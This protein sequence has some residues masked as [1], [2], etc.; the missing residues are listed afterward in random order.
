M[1]SEYRPESLT[2]LLCC[3]IDW[4]H[5]AVDICGTLPSGE[6]LL[7]AI[8]Y[9]STW[10]EI[11]MLYSTST[12]EVVNCLDNWFASHGQPKLVV[13]DNG[14]Q[15]TSTDF[16]QFFNENGINH[17]NVTPYYPRANGEVERQ[18]RTIMKAI[19]TTRQVLGRPICD[20]EPVSFS[21]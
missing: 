4:Q 5:I 14:V 9:Y 6:S 7:V 8:G 1:S 16:V 12:A 2:P 13:T 15:F 19:K 17:R 20:R 21:N 3:L 11:A 10:F 18:N